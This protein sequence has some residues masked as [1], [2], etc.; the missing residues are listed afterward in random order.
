MTSE[1]YR[2]GFIRAC[3]LLRNNHKRYKQVHV[4]LMDAYNRG[5]ITETDFKVVNQIW[6]T[7]GIVSTKQPVVL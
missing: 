1:Q 5:A 6:R 3:Q 4:D 2:E 7:F